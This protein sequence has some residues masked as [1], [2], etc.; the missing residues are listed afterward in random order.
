MKTKAHLYISGRVQGV[1]YRAFTQEVADSLGLKGWVRNLPDGRVEAVFE[2]ER[3]L[4]EEAIL[5]CKQGPP[6][7][8]VTNID[9]TWEN[10]PEGFSDFSI[11]Y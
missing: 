2:G 10:Q 4:I 9:V 1:Y 6:Y 8:N 7:A 3:E 11:R 5:K